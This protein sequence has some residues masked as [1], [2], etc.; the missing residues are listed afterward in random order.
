MFY[1]LGPMIGFSVLHPQMAI[2]AIA[3]VW[4]LVYVCVFAFPLA[5]VISQAEKYFSGRLKIW[6]TVAA[7]TLV[8]AA[9]SL[10]WLSLA[11]GFRNG[12]LRSWVISPWGT[13][14]WALA[15]QFAIA[16][17]L[18]ASISAFAAAGLRRGI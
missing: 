16:G 17:A 11:I 3:A 6:P 1:F 2:L 18:P 15:L 13:S 12:P 7:T 4:L 10:T 5:F 8:G 14:D 9:A